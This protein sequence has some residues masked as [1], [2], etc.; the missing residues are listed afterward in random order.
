VAQAAPRRSAPSRR[1]TLMSLSVVRS[2]VRQRWQPDVRPAT[3]GIDAGVMSQSSDRKQCIRAVF[4]R[5]RTATSSDL[6]GGQQSLQTR[7]RGPLCI[8]ASN[9]CSRVVPA[10][11]RRMKTNRGFCRKSRFVQVPAGTASRPMRFV[12]TAQLQ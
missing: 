10:R 5:R 8:S 6:Q 12:L 7:S 9:A 4:H 3:R 1:Q 11:L 2:R